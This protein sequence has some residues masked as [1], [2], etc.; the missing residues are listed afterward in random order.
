M[1]NEG[2]SGER[3]IIVHSHPG[4]FFIMSTEFDRGISD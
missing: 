2:N 1:A 4:K 3:F